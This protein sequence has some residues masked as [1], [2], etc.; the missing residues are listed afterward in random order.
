MIVEGGGMAAGVCEGGG[1][2]MIILKWW[3]V[4]EICEIFRHEGR[5]WREIDEGVEREREQT[6]WRKKKNVSFRFDSGLD[7]LLCIYLKRFDEKKKIND[8]DLIEEVS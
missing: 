2:A 5:E 4:D 7:L 8:F 3:P 6:K 1:A